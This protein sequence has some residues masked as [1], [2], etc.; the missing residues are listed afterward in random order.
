MKKQTV[1]AILSLSLLVSAPFAQTA[2]AAS[3][4]TKTHQVATN[5]ISQAD[6][7]KAKNALISELNYTKVSTRS[8]E[9]KA[10]GL[11]KKV[12]E[13]SGLTPKQR[14]TFVSRAKSIKSKA[15]NA[16]KSVDTLR[17]SVTNAKTLKEIESLKGR[18]LKIRSDVAVQYDL[19]VILSNE[20]D[21]KVYASP[22]S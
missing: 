3:K 9:L 22:N 12:L 6:L 11:Y 4:T 14:Q 5:S 16:D 19:L 7:L 8:L 15:I 1:V 13:K 17:K 21:G 10:D 18:H 20:I 2:D